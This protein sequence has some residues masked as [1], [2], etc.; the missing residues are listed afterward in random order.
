M[1]RSKKKLKKRRK[2]ACKCVKCKKTL[3]GKKKH[4]KR[5]LKKSYK[6]CVKS[7]RSKRRGRSKRKSKKKYKKVYKNIR[8]YKQSGCSRQKG[9]YKC[10]EATNMGSIYG[11]N[12]LNLLTRDITRAQ[13]TQN[14]MINGGGF[15]INAGLG[16]G[17]DVINSIGNGIK[18]T[19]RT[20][21]GDHHV[22]DSDVTVASDMMK[23]N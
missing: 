1:P 22:Q 8:R 21:Y 13:S 19:M 18:N 23:H 10:N 12:K 3:K 4:C 9:G 5:C 17:I 6:C 7:T 15:A 14:N 20:V 16:K 2:C 11:G